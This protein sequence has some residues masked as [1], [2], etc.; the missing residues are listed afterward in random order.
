MGSARRDARVPL[1]GPPVAGHRRCQPGRCAL[2]NGH[3]RACPGVGLVRAAIRP[4]L[5]GPRQSAGSA[6]TWL[7]SERPWAQPGRCVAPLYGLAPGPSG[8]VR[9][10]C[11]RLNGLEP[12]RIP[13]GAL[14][15]A[16]ARAANATKKEKGGPKSP[17]TPPSLLGC[18]LLLDYRL[19]STDV[20][21]WAWPACVA[22][23][24]LARA[25][26]NT[27]PVRHVLLLKWWQG[28]FRP[29]TVRL[30]R[31]VVHLSTC[32]EHFPGVP[33]L[34]PPLPL[35]ESPTPTILFA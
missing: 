20:Y 6:G 31:V 13:V 25:A 3:D 5:P 16:A 2:L 35:L 19:P 24:V 14:N 29:P 32:Q 27:C 17:L 8:E 30:D 18:C 22:P 7:S 26:V 12:G 21:P 34:Q 4:G 9:D 10:R 23:H 11:V 28:D 1:H 15:R 33:R